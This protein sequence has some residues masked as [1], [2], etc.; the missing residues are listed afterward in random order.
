MNKI[1]VFGWI[2]FFIAGSFS[3]V[4]SFVSASSELV[5]D[6]WNA[7]ASMS[8]ARYGLG[9]VAVDGKIYA[10]GGCADESLVGTNECY[11]PVTD[12]WSTLTSMPVPMVYFAIVEYQ[13]KIYCIGTRGVTVV[14]DI[15]TD[16]WSTKGSSPVFTLI[17]AQ[18]VDEKIFV[19]DAQNEKLC[20]YDPVTDS[21]TEKARL[22]EQQSAHYAGSIFSTAV[23]N[24]IFA[25]CHIIEH[26]FTWKK[27]IVII[28]DPNL[29]AWSEKGSYSDTL[30][31]TI[32]K[33]AGATT[34]CFAPQRV[35]AFLPNSTFV[36]D[37]VRNT[38]STTKAMPTER[39]YFGVAVVDDV[40]YVIGGCTDLFADPR[41]GYKE[42]SSVNEQYV[43]IG[44]NSTSSRSFLTGSA[45]IVI[46]LIA[47]VIVAS[48]FFYLRGRKSNKRLVGYA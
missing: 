19:I 31:D 44:Y 16:C 5:E 39:Q 25:R 14:Y 26:Y 20:H 38:W 2:L 3:M 34:G 4:Y 33:G 21:W 12:T 48:L 10:I 22:P 41:V 35:Y 28:Y 40:L 17:S 7:K 13:G 23:D 18:V 6:S 36:Y 24:K 43:P 32:S 27:D 42:F 47:F 46:V 9:V 30:L 37:P 15:A 8:Q 29:D 45:V 1:L 11:D